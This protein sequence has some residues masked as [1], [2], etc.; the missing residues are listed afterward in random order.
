M[1][2]VEALQVSSDNTNCYVH[3]VI[4]AL[5][6]I[7]RFFNRCHVLESYQEL[8]TLEKYKSKT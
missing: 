7:L 2:I 5:L 6:V 1:K 4:K 8:S 3:Y